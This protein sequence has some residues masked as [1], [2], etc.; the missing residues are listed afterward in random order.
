M[1]QI[2]R[3]TNKEEYLKD[4][5]F[6]GIGS[7]IANQLNLSKPYVRSVLN[8]KFPNRKTKNTRMIK[9]LAAEIMK[10]RMEEQNSKK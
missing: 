4:R 5:Y 10:E 3:K 1:K 8:D 6:F 9:A 7:I 2:K